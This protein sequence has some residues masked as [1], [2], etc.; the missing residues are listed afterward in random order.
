VTALRSTPRISAPNGFPL[1]RTAN[2]DAVEVLKFMFCVSEPG[3]S[4]SH[5]I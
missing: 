2:V 3:V 5:P 1:G 4:A